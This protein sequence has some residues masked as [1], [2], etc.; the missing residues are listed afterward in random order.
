M[1]E[2]TKKRRPA[3]NPPRGFGLQVRAV[4]Q[5]AKRAVQAE[6]KERLLAEQDI[7]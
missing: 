7:A 1:K 5:A 2:R 3:G 4:L 6:A